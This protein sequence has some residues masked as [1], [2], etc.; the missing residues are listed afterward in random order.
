MDIDA[1]IKQNPNLKNVIIFILLIFK[2]KSGKDKTY[3]KLILT[4]PRFKNARL[5]KPRF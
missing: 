4:K 1:V 3:M 5:R 2:E